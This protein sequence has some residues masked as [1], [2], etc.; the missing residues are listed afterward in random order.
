MKD[1]S[2][3]ILLSGNYLRASNTGTFHCSVRTVQPIPETCQEF[4]FEVKIVK[5]SV[6]LFIGLSAPGSNVNRHIGSFPNSYGYRCD[7]GMKGNADRWKVYGPKFSTN[8]IIGCG[9]FDSQCFFT[10]NGVFLGMA[11][12]DVPP[13]LCPTVY[14]GG[15]DV[16][17]A[18]FGQTPYDYDLNWDELRSL[19]R[20]PLPSQWSSKCESSVIKLSR[21]NRWALC[22]RTLFGSVRSDHPIPAACAAF[23]FEVTIVSAVVNV[24]IGLSAANSNLDKT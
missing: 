9:V 20:S 18:N 7:N 1:K 11:F 4:Y 21:N 22:E 12:G 17:T 10:K 24:A 8:D 5:T 13:N 14:L 15:R 16:V 19:V 2:A 23:Y 3:S 6:L